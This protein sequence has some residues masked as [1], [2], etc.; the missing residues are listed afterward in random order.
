MPDVHQQ[1]VQIEWRLILDDGSNAVKIVPITGGELLIGRALTTDLHLDD[2]RISR[3]HARL[4]RR[5]DQLLIEDLQTVNG[6]LVNG[7][8]V[9]GLQVLQPHDAIGLGPFTLKVDQAPAPQSRRET[10]AYTLPTSPN[11]KLGLLIAAAVVGLS[12]I[13]L[14]IGWYWLGLANRREQASPAVSTGPVLTLTQAPAHNSA[15][16]LDRPVTVQAMASDAA[17][18]SRVELWVNGRKVDEVDTQLVGVAPTLNAALQWQPDR[19]GLYALELRAYNEAGQVTIQPVADLTVIGQPD[20]PTPIPSPLPSPTVVPL[21]PTDTPAPTPT[22]TPLPSPTP[23]PATA[24]PSQAMLTITAPALNVRIGPGTQYNLIGQLVQ[25]EQAEIVGQASAGQALWWEIRFA[26]GPGGLGWV[27][28]DPSFGASSNTA[29]VPPVSVPTLAS[30]PAA[31]VAPTQTPLP[32]APATPTTPTGTVIRAPAGKTLLLVSNRSLSNQ[33]AL[34]TLSGGKSVGGGREVDAL[35]G[36]DIRLVLEPDFYRAMW[37]SPARPGGFVRGADFMAVK[38]KIIV[39]WIV[40]EEGR[41]DTEL[42]DELI[43]GS[44]APTATPAPVG[45][46]TP[47]PIQGSYPSAPPGKAL[48]VAANRTLN[49]SYADLTLSGGSFGGGQAVKLDAGVEIP[50]ELLPGDYRAV[51]TSPARRGG[52]SAGREFKVSAG[53]VI[54]SWIIPDQGQVFMQFPGQEPIQ[55]NN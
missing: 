10:R 24:T 16:P 6:T 17:G 11:T 1:P 48:F 51:W 13:G 37:S 20:T 12:L 8:P 49:N 31:S 43:I 44:P 42:Y 21:L 36:G 15:I 45:T 47:N 14:L 50:L 23:V 3:H 26:A 18:V 34:L 54:L 27:S 30:A 52:F 5:G 46:A 7:Q 28:A 39:M 41:T 29:G 4:T 33:P 19:P 38:D 40:P 22:T 55:I 53:E 2:A 35:A 32:T 25:G 9:T